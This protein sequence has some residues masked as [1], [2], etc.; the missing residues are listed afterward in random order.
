MT[1]VSDVFHVDRG[2]EGFIEQLRA[3]GADVVRV[4]ADD[5]LG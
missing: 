2:Y 1:E 5:L 3:L 4:P